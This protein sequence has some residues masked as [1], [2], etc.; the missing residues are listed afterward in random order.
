MRFDKVPCVYILASKPYGTIYIGVTSDL[1]FRMS[2]HVEG[3]SPG[4]T[5]RYGVK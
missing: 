4:F 1:P 2:Q 3:L 5:K